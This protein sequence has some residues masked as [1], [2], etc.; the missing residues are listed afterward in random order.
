MWILISEGLSFL[1]FV[2]GVFELFS[3]LAF[4]EKFIH[5][6]FSKKS[7]KFIARIFGLILIILGGFLMFSFRAELS[8]QGIFPV[9]IIVSFGLLLLQSILVIIFGQK[10]MTEQIK[11]LIGSFNDTFYID[12][13]NYSELPIRVWGMLILIISVFIVACV[14]SSTFL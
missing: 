12:E 13:E 11:E 1:L 2:W 6:N 14:L 9:L 8:T 3:G 10:G 5:T 7:K 4:W